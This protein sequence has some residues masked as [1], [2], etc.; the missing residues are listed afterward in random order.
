MDEELCLWFSR[1]WFAFKERQ[2]R[3]PSR[4]EWEKL[5]GAAT[6]SQDDPLFQPGS[7]ILDELVL[8]SFRTLDIEDAMEDDLHLKFR[9]AY[10]NSLCRKYVDGSF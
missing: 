10:T 5:V 7:R 9:A 4:T 3:S 1:Y 2:G 8:E 6:R